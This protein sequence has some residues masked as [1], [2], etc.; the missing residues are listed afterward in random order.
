VAKNLRSTSRKPLLK[1][2]G[3]ASADAIGRVVL[4]AFA[5]IILS[6]L[7]SV[8]DF[9]ISAIVLAI[10]AAAGFLVGTPFEEAL[11]Q[12]RVLRTVDLRSAF[13]MSMLLG[14]V[15]ILVSILVG[16]WLADLYDTPE[17]AWLL[18]VVMVSILFN[19]HGDLSTALARRRRRFEDIAA[20]SLISHAVGVVV[21]IAMAFAGFGLLALVAL[22]L[23]VVLVRSV[24][25]QS[26]Q[27]YPLAPQISFKSLRALAHHA[28]I[29]FFD[30]L[31]ENLTY[32]VFA[33]LVGLFHGLTSVGYLNMALRVVEPIRGAII[34]TTHNLSFPYFRRVS[35]GLEPVVARDRIIHLLAFIITAVF[36]GLAAIMPAMIPFVAGPGWE[37]AVFIAICL[38]A[39]AAIVLPTRLISTSLIASGHPIYS[40]FGNL[41]SL[42]LVTLCLLLGRDGPDYLIGLSRLLADFGQAMVTLIVPLGFL[43]WSQS[44]RFRAILP[45][46]ALAALMGLSV[47]VIGHYLAPLGYITTL[48]VQVIAGIAIQVG[49]MWLFCNQE[50][51]QLI[52]FMRGRDLGTD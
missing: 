33:N 48:A 30:R 28:S 18:P 25:L 47:G 31:A 7:V 44:S 37:D 29:S 2:I 12:R 34:A 42:S 22:R 3:W 40:L 43:A 52:N 35:H 27:R 26:T 20:A 19:G 46:W 14:A 6:R 36:A 5:T 50:M 10:A 45:A 39:G 49:L 51:R 38:S 1:S 9:G 4:L 16:P 24:V 32:L 23:V 21:T 8:E 41:T 17:M 13:T 11:V 15:L